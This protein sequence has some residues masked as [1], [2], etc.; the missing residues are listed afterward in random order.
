MET[1]PPTQRG[2]QAGRDTPLNPHR[3]GAQGGARPTEGINRGVSTSTSPSRS[4]EKA[5][6][7]LEGWEGETE[8][9]TARM[10]I[11]TAATRRLL[12]GANSRWSEYAAMRSRP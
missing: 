12:A 5:Q 6:K 8:K 11:Q 1:D 7:E 3:P 4:V 9:T 10:Q 2:D